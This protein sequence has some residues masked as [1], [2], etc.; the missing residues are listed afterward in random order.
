MQAIKN[1]GPHLLRFDMGRR[2]SESNLADGQ[3]LE[4]GDV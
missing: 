3:P 4:A 1:D 2:L